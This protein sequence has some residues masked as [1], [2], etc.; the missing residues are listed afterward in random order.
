[1]EINSFSNQTGVNLAAVDLLFDE[2]SAGHAPYFL[3]LNF[4]FGRRG[5][6]G[7]IAYY[8]LLLGAIKVWLGEEGLD[9]EAVRLV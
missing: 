2:D 7:T 6:G 1:V 8:R 5:L 3:E 4:Y 9:P